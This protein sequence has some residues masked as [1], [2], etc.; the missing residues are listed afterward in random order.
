MSV[1]CFGRTIGASHATP[2]AIPSIFTRA[3]GESDIAVQQL[4]RALKAS[5]QV[6]LKPKGE[7]MMPSKQRP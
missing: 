5:E 3:L 2:R 1:V 7:T 4:E 6:S